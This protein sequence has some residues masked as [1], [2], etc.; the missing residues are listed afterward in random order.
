MSCPWSAWLQAPAEFCEESLC[1]WIREPAN[2]WSK[3]GF[4]LVA[5]FVLFETRRVDRRHLRPL[6]WIMGLT[7]IGSAFFHASETFPGVLADYLGMFLGLAWMLSI[8]ATR[9]FSWSGTASSAFFWGLSATC[10]GAQIVW[11]ESARWVYLLLGVICGVSEVAM[12]FHPAMRAAHYGWYSLFWAALIPAVA[13][14][15]VDLNGSWCDPTNHRLN[16]HALWHLFN[17]AGF[18]A[19]YR[20]YLQF[21]A[22][23]R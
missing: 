9:W 11:P 21:E 16:G 22:V 14:W 10:I 8:C 12:I 23:R 2:T 6:A 5:G 7:G 13:F 18:Y 20:Y 15:V 19:A 3:V 17:A 1:A 4:V